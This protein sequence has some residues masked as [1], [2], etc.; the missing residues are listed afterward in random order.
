MATLNLASAVVMGLFLFG[1]VVFVLQARHW[2]RGAPTLEAGP[3]R[4]GRALNRPAAWIAVFAV[5]AFGLAGGVV[6]YVS[7]GEGSTAIGVSQGAI[8][9]AIGA[10]FGVL[11]SALLFAGVYSSVKGRGG[12]TSMAVAVGSGVVGMLFLVGLTLKLILG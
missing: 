1:M 12:P 7:A 11:L 8:G 6:L 9:T 10:A 2:E 3:S 4:L 5:V